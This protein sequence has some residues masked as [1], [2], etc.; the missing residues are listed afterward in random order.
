MHRAELQVG[1]SDRL[2]VELTRGSRES[3]FQEK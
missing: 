3:E 1:H 2:Q